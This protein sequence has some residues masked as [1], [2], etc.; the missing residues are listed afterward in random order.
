MFPGNWE[1]LGVYLKSEWT[2]KE[3]KNFICSFH[4]YMIS[5]YCVSSY[6]KI[7][8]FFYNRQ[9]A[10]PSENLPGLRSFLVDHYKSDFIL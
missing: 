3:K 5:T 9:K 10:L 1:Y 4:K 6:A 2:M 7:E 8:K